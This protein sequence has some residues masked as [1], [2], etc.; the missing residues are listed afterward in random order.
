MKH[1]NA[2]SQFVGAANKI[3][4]LIPTE[5]P[6]SQLRVDTFGQVR[7]TG[8]SDDGWSPLMDTVSQAFAQVH[9]SD[10]EAVD[11]GPISTAGL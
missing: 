10:F 11:T 5:K 6:S 2:G 7:Y 8:D 9:G 3:I 4:A 1:S